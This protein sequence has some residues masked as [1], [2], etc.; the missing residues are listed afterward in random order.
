M[1][2][3][4]GRCAMRAISKLQH[5]QHNN[6]SVCCFDAGCGTLSPSYREIRIVRVSGHQ[7]VVSAHHRAKGL[8]GI[9]DLDADDMLNIMCSVRF[10]QG[11][12]HW[13]KSQCFKKREEIHLALAEGKEFKCVAQPASKA[14]ARRT[15]KRTELLFSIN[16]IN[17][18][19]SI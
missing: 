11:A 7:C 3:L 17:L 8:P 10:V 18:E 12:S 5:L 19:L 1:L 16:Y 2:D 13:P 14:V 15:A 6:N 9:L 4:L